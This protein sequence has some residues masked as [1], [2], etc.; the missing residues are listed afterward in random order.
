MAMKRRDRIST[1][2]AMA[3]VT[4]LLL[5]P[6]VGCTIGGEAKPTLAHTTSAE[7]TQRIFWQDVKDKKW[8]QIQ[9][10]LVANV[11]WRNGKETLTR[12]QIVPYL[13][14]LQLK[15]VLLTNVVVN[16]DGND[17]TV[18]YDVQLTS[19]TSPQP[20]DLHALAVWQQVPAPPDTASK[21]VKKQADKASPYLL[22]V[23]DLTP[24]AAKP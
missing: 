17:M 3:A 23:E 7:Q 15:E 11:T 8:L 5:V 19:S 13:Q 24:D 4:L 12:D 10:L 16:A 1:A 14:Q 6:S 21:Q 18:L 20:M 2:A 9:G 22:T